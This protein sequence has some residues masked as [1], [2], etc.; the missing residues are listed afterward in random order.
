MALTFTPPIAP[1]PGTT[2]KPTFKLLKAEFGDGY[3]QTTRHGLNHRRRS[4]SLTWETLT[5]AQAAT[6]IDFLN[7]RGGDEPFWYTPSDELVPIL[8]TCEE[9]EDKRKQGGLRT[10]SAVFVESFNLDA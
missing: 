8:W 2:V 9:F 6:I 3:T 5:P 1:S 7:A 10:V 4:I